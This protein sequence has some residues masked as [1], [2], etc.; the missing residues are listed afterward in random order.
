MND[1][2]FGLL[3]CT[4]DVEVAPM[5]YEKFKKIRKG[6]VGEIWQKQVDLQLFQF[7]KFTLSLC[8]AD[9]LQVIQELKK[10][11]ELTETQFKAW[12]HFI[13]NVPAYEE[14]MKPTILAHY[15]ELV[16]GTEYFGR[17]FEETTDF[18]V[19]QPYLSKPLVSIGQY[20]RQGEL[21]LEIRFQCEYDPEHGVGCSF[22]DGQLTECD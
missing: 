8:S 17:T 18:T 21:H 11:G 4:Y 6:T 13:N 20:S 22:V 3:T 9:S 14:Q 12:T 1:P 16:S 7:P 15:N 19:V 2:N 10:E 5:W